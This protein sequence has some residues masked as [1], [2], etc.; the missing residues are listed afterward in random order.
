MSS[1]RFS[2]DQVS[3]TADSV[4][5]GGE[6]KEPETKKPEQAQEN[7][8]QPEA[9][10][11]EQKAPEV[12]EVSLSERQMQAIQE[13]QERLEEAMRLVNGLHEAAQ[14]AKN[15]AARQAKEIIS[16]A[17]ARAQQMMLD[18]EA[19][20]E[21]ETEAGRQRG[22]A[23]GM[24][25]AEQ[26]ALERKKFEAGELQNMIDSVRAER[27]RMIDS[28]EGEIIE[29]VIEIAKKTI[30][31]QIGDNE[32]FL[33][34]VRSEMAQLKSMDG[35]TLSVAVEDFVR[36]FGSTEGVAAQFP[37]GNVKVVA[38]KEL[39]EGDCIIETEAEV[40]DCGVNGQLE[41]V[42]ELLR[43]EIGEE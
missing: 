32:V 9:Q 2:R 20:I 35:I 28:L 37:D 15:D 30:R 38:D 22:Y 40:V 33:G 25:K 7:A 5:I 18:A 14:A 3:V 34:I 42:E 4:K 24:A 43:E 19:A 31:S 8:G 36:L 11:Q 26:E 39:S 29:T 21:Q 12:R 13:K 1:F 17:E 23:E 16:D 41:R 10:G 6:Q 27:Q